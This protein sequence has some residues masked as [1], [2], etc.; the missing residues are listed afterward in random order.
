MIF[1][2]EL[3][4][5]DSWMFSLLLR[6]LAISF[7]GLALAACGTHPKPDPEVQQIY[8]IR[9]LVVTANEG[10]SAALVRG[11]KLRLDKAIEDTVRP[12]PLP[13]AV[14]NVQ[15]LSLTKT[16]GYD[17][18]RAETEVSVTLTDDV[19]AQPLLAR[20]FLIYSFSINL[21]DAND[22]AA[23]A[24]ASRLR[25][26]YALSQPTI[27]N[28]QPAGRISTQ[29]NDT[30][31]VP[32]GAKEGKPLV[33]PL[34][35]APA[36]GVDQDPV[37]NSKTKIAPADQNLAFPEK[38]VLSDKKA[39]TSDTKPKV[40]NAV[41]AENA[42]EAGAKVKVMIKPKSTAPAS[43]EPCVETMDKKC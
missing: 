32:L 39:A 34:A 1:R 8:D 9:G 43:D 41:P 23:E 31:L 30:T 36:I 25:V 14:M 12:A 11:I 6:A 21:R 24:V 22:S 7:V 33:V 38:P 17:G 3:V 18:V 4:S 40:A 37:L 27:R 13:R 29:M 16:S 20:S 2:L 28:A 10:I 19:S 42:L 5:G 15:I 26:E 35:T